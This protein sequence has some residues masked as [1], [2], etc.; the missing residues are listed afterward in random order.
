MGRTFRRNDRWKKDRKDKNF[1]NS[2]KFKTAHQGNQPNTGKPVDTPL[3]EDY[4][5]SI[6][7]P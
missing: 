1:R 6:D 4:D 5:N 3:D 2:K 7:S